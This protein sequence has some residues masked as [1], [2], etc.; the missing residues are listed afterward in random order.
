M[1]NV[2]IGQRVLLGIQ[3]RAER[4]RSAAIGTP[5]EPAA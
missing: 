1:N 3:E 4:S 2:V 5:D